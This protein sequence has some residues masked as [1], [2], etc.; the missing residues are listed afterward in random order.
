MQDIPSLSLKQS[1]CQYV[2]VWKSAALRGIAQTLSQQTDILS[3]IIWSMQRH[4]SH[5]CVVMK[6][7][8]AREHFR[9]YSELSLFAHVF[10]VTEP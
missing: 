5:R 2:A 4:V 10:S 1:V 8:H 9:Y 3:Y 6:K 7:A